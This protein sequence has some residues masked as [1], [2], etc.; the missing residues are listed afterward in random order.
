MAAAVRNSL[1]VTKSFAFRGVT[2]LWSNRY[3]FD[4]ALPADPAHWTTFA[5]GVVN[6]EKLCLT[7]SVTIVQVDGYA[8]GSD[9]PVFTKAYTTVGS[10]AVSAVIQ[11][12]EVVA[13]VRFSTA[14]RTSKNHPLYLFNYFH[15]VETTSS[16]APDTLLVARKNLFTTYATA[17]V[18]GFSDGTNILKR[19]GPQGQLATGV[20]VSSFVTH[21]D[22]PRD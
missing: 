18:T 8:P 3:Y 13:L 12:G 5:D 6:A 9:V 15:S 20:L 10:V 11:T 2:R 1:K 4:G 21:R 22:F 7:S 14:S 19:C 16:A 17:W